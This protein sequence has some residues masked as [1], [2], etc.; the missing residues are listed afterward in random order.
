MH[1]IPP[2]YALLL[3]F[4]A[5]QRIFELVHSRR[6]L[7]AP[8]TRRAPAAEGTLG[9]AAMG[10]LHVGLIVLPLLELGLL[11]GS[12]P[13]SVQTLALLA[14]FLAQGLR[15]WSLYSLGESWNVRAIVS[16][17]L[18]VVTDG[19]YRW[20]RHPNY[21]AVCIEFVS[22]P[23]IGG[24]WLSLVLLNLLHAPLIARRMRVEEEHLRTV[25]GWSE[26][27]EDKGRLWPRLRGWRS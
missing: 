7:A 11:G 16:T 12:S 6:N 1:S 14:F 15:Y 24:A 25:P 10:G 22:L 26:A 17:D 8:S 21:L 4:V 27:M 5:A 23:A 18:P 19:P 20:I 13:S 9:F 2:F 3:A